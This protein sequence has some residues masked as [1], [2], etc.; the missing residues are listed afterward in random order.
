MI[1]LYKSNYY[2]GVRV[3]YTGED[4]EIGASGKF[5]K[6]FKETYFIYLQNSNLQN[7]N[8]LPLTAVQMMN[9]TG[10]DVFLFNN[11]RQR[12]NSHYVLTFVIDFNCEY[13]VFISYLKQ[14]YF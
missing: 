14:F 10:A 8:K 2:T 13:K 1:K 9:S 7:R 5:T 6:N 3:Y 12:E 11:N 4:A